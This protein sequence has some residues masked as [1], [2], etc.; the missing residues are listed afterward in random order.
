MTEALPVTRN[1]QAATAGEWRE[2]PPR[3]KR[4]VVFDSI[5]QDPDIPR[6]LQSAGFEVVPKRNLSEAASAAG[7]P[8]LIL[9]Q[10]HELTAADRI[11][12]EGIRA[13]CPGVLIIGVGTPV[14]V[15]LARGRRSARNTAD[16]RRGSKKRRVFDDF[17][18]A[19]FEASRLICLLQAWELAGS[20]RQHATSRSAV[21]VSAIE[22]LASMGGHKLIEELLAPSANAV[23]D[24]L[25]AIR[26]ALTNRD[27]IGLRHAAHNLK[28]TSGVFGAASMS[29]IAGLLEN[30]GRAGLQDG[31]SVLADS[32]EEEVGRFT[33]DLR[34]LARSIAGAGEKPLL[35]AL[36]RPALN[37]REM[38]GAFQGR[39]IA[40]YG[41][42]RVSAD[43]LDTTVR[44]LDAAFTV[45]TGADWLSGAWADNHDLMIVSLGSEDLP[46]LK[47]C[48][49]L[50]AGTRPILVHLRDN[51]QEL[52]DIAE[53]ASAH[54]LP[55]SETNDIVLAAHQI[56]LGLKTIPEGP[57]EQSSGIV[58]PARDACVAVA[59]LLVAE[60]E[61][62]T[63]RFL[64]GS[65]EAGGF[66]VTHAATG[67]EA[68]DLLA[69]RRFD[70][71]VLDVNMP[72]ADGY[73]VL[74]QLRH[75]P[76]NRETPVLM[77]SARN[78][79]RDIV[80]AFDLGADDY[81]TKPFSPPEVVL[82]L[83]KLTGRQ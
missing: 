2:A 28:S 69:T 9:A 50:E 52:L 51:R 78:Q 10:I 77:L 76:L 48:R 64:I 55:P 66:E 25:T 41:F 40:A 24:S 54:V 65:L 33:S 68:I 6:A 61:P 3:R 45:V 75:D 37:L 70:A 1:S 46:D 57:T 49:T 39:R 43:R 27:S 5:L 63:A 53:L 73:D 16:R 7:S 15:A 81:V 56:L 17:I 36:E 58:F 83:R 23:H 34:S 35:G 38:S 4:V 22:A 79:E 80:K 31:G 26:Q 42:D 47:N 67:A 82:R 71:A 19:P 32:L 18:S 12:V 11:A 60:D 21:N 29:E 44:S 8:E 74:A 14:A 59:H 62:L 20:I 72:E 30:M 13:A